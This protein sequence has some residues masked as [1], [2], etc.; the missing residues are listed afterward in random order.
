MNRTRQDTSVDHSRDLRGLA[1]LS[2]PTGVVVVSGWALQVL[3]LHVLGD[4]GYATFIF[5]LGVG[6]VSAV[7]GSAIQPVSASLALAGRPPLRVK[8]GPTTAAAIGAFTVV[9]TLAT[10]PSTGWLVAFAAM[11]QLPLNI[12]LGAVSGELQARR[13]YRVLSLGLL[14]WTIGRIACAVALDV[15]LDSELALLL[16]LPMALLLQLSYLELHRRRSSQSLQAGGLNSFPLQLL[17]TW[18]VVAWLLYGDGVLARIVL[19]PASAANYGV[20]LT[21][22]RQA[23][24]IAAPA[25]TVLLPVT[26]DADAR[27]RK[28]IFFLMLLATAGVLVLASVSLMIRPDLV[29]HVLLVRLPGSPAAIRIYALSGSFG[30]G[31]LLAAS[32][33][34]GTTQRMNLPGLACV[35]AVSLLSALTLVHSSLSL[36]ALQAV[37]AAAMFGILVRDSRKSVSSVGRRAVVAVPG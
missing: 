7:I 32:F 33:L 23:M 30:F 34:T 10:G 25:A 35:A 36:A 4:E 18:G 31:S 17:M 24:Y 8:S 6:G 19:S 28:R 12:V 16:C 3:A 13:A 1:W 29:V 15:A 37:T 2:A 11:S 26:V 14:I 5:S 22:G 27:T 21:L 20:A 9:G